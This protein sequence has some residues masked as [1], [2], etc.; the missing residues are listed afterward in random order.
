MCNVASVV[1]SGHDTMSTW[2]Y[3]FKSNSQTSS[4]HSGLT[5]SSRPF[6]IGHLAHC[7]MNAYQYVI[8]DDLNSGPLIL[9]AEEGV[10]NHIK[11]L[12]KNQVHLLRLTN[13]T[14]IQH[15]VTRLKKKL[16]FSHG[17]TV[18]SS[19]IYYIPKLNRS[20]VD[21]SQPTWQIV[22]GHKHTF[23]LWK[24][25]ARLRNVMQHKQTIS[26]SRLGFASTLVVRCISYLD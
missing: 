20:I 5:C 10:Q 4:W 6:S 2:L 13:Q 7:A 24:E 8:F 18:P 23:A 16:K 17:S 21:C 3:F 11:S 26:M 14:M 25:E 12:T 19:T 15:P 1:S 9:P 22:C